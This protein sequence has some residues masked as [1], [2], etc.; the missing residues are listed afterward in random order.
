M[1]SQFLPQTYCLG[2]CIFHKISGVHSQVWEAGGLYLGALPGVDEAVDHAEVVERGAEGAAWSP[3]GAGREGAV[4][5]RPLAAAIAGAV[6]QLQGVWR[7]LRDGAGGEGAARG[8]LGP[9]DP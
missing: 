3:A 1:E 9:L 4:V 8:H 5:G 7:G 2:I 6:T